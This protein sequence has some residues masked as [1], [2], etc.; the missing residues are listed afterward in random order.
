MAK[1]KFSVVISHI[2]AEQ[3]AAVLKA[4]TLDEDGQRVEVDSLVKSGVDI[5]TAHQ[6]AIAFV[7]KNTEVEDGE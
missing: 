6:L 7:D 5:S 3:Y 2:T 4:W 1:V